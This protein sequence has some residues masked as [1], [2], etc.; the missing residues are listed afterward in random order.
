[1]G[2]TK[3]EI[4]QW[5]V[6]LVT[7]WE[8]LHT[9]QFSWM[10]RSCK[11]MLRHW[12]VWDLLKYKTILI[13]VARGSNLSVQPCGPGQVTIR[14][15]AW[16]K[17]DQWWKTG[18]LMWHDLTAVRS[19]KL[20]SSFR[21]ACLSVESWQTGRLEDFMSSC[22]NSTSRLLWS[23]SGIKVEMTLPHI[24]TSLSEVCCHCDA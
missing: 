3:Q 6:C 22:H 13:I 21:W 12:L 20:L 18:T 15:F 1:M 8:M 7:E 17:K 9:E 16:I 14:N 10:S 23:D 24:D 5:L 4:T 2:W 19:N 11:A